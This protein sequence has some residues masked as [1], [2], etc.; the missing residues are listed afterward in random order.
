MGELYQSGSIIIRFYANDHLPPHFH[1]LT[2]D[3]EALVEIATLRLLAGALP[4]KI[5]R[6]ALAWAAENR[7]AVAAEWNRTNA[8]F[9]IA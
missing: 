6:E 8:R 5:E 2:P 3:D 7:A 4:G 9:P 1:I